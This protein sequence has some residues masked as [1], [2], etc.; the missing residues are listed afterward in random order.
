MRT[1]LHVMMFGSILI[2]HKFSRQQRWEQKKTERIERQMHFGYRN[3]SYKDTQQE[4]VHF[5]WF[6]SRFIDL[7]LSLSLALCVSKYSG[8]T[9]YSNW[10]CCKAEQLRHLPIS[11]TGITHTKSK[12]QYNNIFYTKNNTVCCFYFQVDV[13]N[14]YSV[15]KKTQCPFNW[16][17]T[18]M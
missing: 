7:S 10:N 8:Q 14:F 15:T 13:V 6:Y 1:T 4:S 12:K 2:S 3:I 11:I 17:S 5:L 16:M 18:K 9:H